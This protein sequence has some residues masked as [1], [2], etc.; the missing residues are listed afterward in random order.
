MAVGNKHYFFFLE[1]CKSPDKLRG[2]HNE[3]LNSELRE[4][5]KVLDVLAHTMKVESTDGQLSGLGFNATVKDNVIIRVKG[6]V[7]SIIKVTF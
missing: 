7:N 2:F 3:F 5:R 1:G 4:H 6:E